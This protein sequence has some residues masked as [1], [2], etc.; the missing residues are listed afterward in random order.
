M[1]R[2]RAINYRL[3]TAAAAV[4]MATAVSVSINRLVV[5]AGCTFVA[6]VILDVGIFTAAAGGILLQ[7]RASLMTNGTGGWPR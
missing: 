5:A 4:T 7:I 2:S 3:V 6:G 1:S